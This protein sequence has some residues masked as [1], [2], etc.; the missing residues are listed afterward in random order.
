MK[1]LLR[2]LRGIVGVGLT[3]GVVFVVLMFLVGT[4]IGI[5]DPDSIDPGEEPY[6]IGAIVGVLGFLSGVFFAL[7]LA[8]AERRKPIAELSAGRAAIWGALGAAAFPLLAGMPNAAETLMFVCPLG[9][10]LASTTVAL[11]RRADRAA[12]DR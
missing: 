5:V 9:A 4:I 12:A 7:L 6:R 1:T 2:K 8:L 11:A 3:W 10:A